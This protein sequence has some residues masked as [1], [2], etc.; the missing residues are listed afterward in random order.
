[1]DLQQL[2]CAD[3]EKSSQSFTDMVEAKSQIFQGSK[4]S[5]LNHSGRLL[6]L[7][8]RH[9]S[10]DDLDRSI[11]FNSEE[12]TFMH[13]HSQEKNPSKSICLTRA[14][15]NN[16][17]GDVAATPPQI[18]PSSAISPNDSGIEM[19]PHS[20]HSKSVKCTRFSRSRSFTLSPRLTPTTTKDISPTSLEVS[21]NS[22]RLFPMDKSSNI[23]RRCVLPNI[24]PKTRLRLPHKFKKY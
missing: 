7:K 24:V 3:I 13:K 18:Q 16:N 21:P 2:W 19:T 4:N 6:G 11:T 22:I 15:I 12:S 17:S 8:R 1:M 20:P 23:K 14:D 5:P 9:S 10:F